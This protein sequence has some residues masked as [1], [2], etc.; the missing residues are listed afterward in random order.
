M[1]KIFLQHIRTA[2]LRWYAT[3]K[4]DLPWRRKISFYR[5]WV[6]EIILQQT[7]VKQG[8]TYFET[9]I[10]IFPDFN[11]LAEAEEKDIL[12]I[13]Q[14]LGYYSRAINMHK[15]AKQIVKNLNNTPPETFEEI[16]K[17]KGIGDYTAAAISSIVYNEPHAV[18]DGN[19]FRVLSRFFSDAT[20]I[21]T[22]VGKKHFTDLAYLILDKAHPG[23]FNQAI[24]ELGALV[25]KPKDPFC[26]SCPIKIWCKGYLEWQKFPVK[27]RKI[28]KR[29]RYFNYIIIKDGN[30]I[31]FHQRDNQDIYKKMYEPLLIETDKPQTSDKLINILRKTYIKN[32]KNLVELYDYKKHNLTH[33]TIFYKT[34]VLQN[35]SFD[36]TLLKSFGYFM[37]SLHEVSKYPQSNIVRDILKDV[38]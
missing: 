14:G 17:L 37:I 24:M 23:D 5:V 35:N 18:V 7:Q 26:E 9:F 32:A 28:K 20:P 4:R 13:W 8:I 21:N 10:S 30:N 1:R 34:L 36:I 15:A 2:L 19:V 16:K 12:R 27:K 25:C 11:S 3:Q 29:T 31:L 33:Q 6:S 38:I 22:S